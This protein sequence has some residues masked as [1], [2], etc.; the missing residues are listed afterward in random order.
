MLSRMTS[1]LMRVSL[2]GSTLLVISCAA[3]L[4]IAGVPRLDGFGRPPKAS[5]QLRSV[6]PTVEARPTAAAKTI[7]KPKPSSAAETRAENDDMAQIQ[8]SL[9][10]PASAWLAAHK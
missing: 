6:Q 7:R 8:R 3:Y 9:K 1:R 4:G 5:P 2:V 10:G